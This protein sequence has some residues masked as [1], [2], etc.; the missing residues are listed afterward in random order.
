MANVD[1]SLVQ[2]VP[3]F[4]GLSGKELSSIAGLLRARTF[5]AGN[6]VVTEGQGGAGF[7][8]I[9]S[10]TAQV[11]VEGKHVRTLGPGDHFGEIALL[12]DSVRTAT[13]TA[14]T[15]LNCHGMT[16]WEFRPLVESNNA[17]A[18][19]LLQNV[20]RQLAEAEHR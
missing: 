19:K 12:T 14:E 8:V 20:A 11:T 17:I 2:R 1:K 18:W 7:F 3:L 13:I 10:G 15:D 4:S 6:E 5:P 16:I 9:E